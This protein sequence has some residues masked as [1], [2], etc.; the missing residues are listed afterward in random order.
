MADE[1]D[2]V[3]VWLVERGYNNRDLIILKYATPDGERLF[4]RELAAQ[5]IGVDT[6]TAAKDVSTDDLERIDDS[7]LRERYANEVERM[8]DEHEP[9]DTI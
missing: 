9:D 7:D 3:R 4:R 1:S 8:A 2:T 6:V 5:A